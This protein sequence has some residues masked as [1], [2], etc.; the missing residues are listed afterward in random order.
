MFSRSSPTVQLVLTEH[1]GVLRITTTEVERP[2]G[3]DT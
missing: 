1:A 2:I 3:D